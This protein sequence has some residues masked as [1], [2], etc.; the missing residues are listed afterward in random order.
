ME[1]VETKARKRGFEPHQKK[2]GQH[3]KESSKERQQKNLREENHQKKNERGGD[4]RL[5]GFLSKESS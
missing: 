4:L 3:T 2:V 5:R 1:A